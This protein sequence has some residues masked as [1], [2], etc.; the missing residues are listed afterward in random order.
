MLT[1]IH[2]ADFHLDSPL[3]GLARYEGAPA[4]EIRKASRRALN[5]LVDYILDN[6]IPLLLI[7]GDL[8]DADCPDFQTLLYFSLQMDRL[9]DGGT[10]VA[11]I[12]GNH[13][14]G[15]TMTRS[16]KLPDNVKTFRS[17]HPHTW[18][19]PDLGV[20]IHGQSYGSYQVVDNLALAYPDPVPDFFN[21]GILHT[22]IS[23][24]PGYSGY[25][26]CELNHLLAKGY[27]YWALGHM[28]RPEIIHE[29]PYVIFPGCI[30]GRHIREPGPKGCMRVDVDNSN[31]VSVEKIDLDIFR[32]ETME[33]DI[34]GL[35]TFHQV[36]DQTG[37]QTEDLLSTK[38]DGRPM[39]TRIIYKGSTRAHNE[40]MQNTEELR[41]SIR[42][43]V[44][45]ISR[46]RIWVE[47]IIQN[48]S[49][50]IDL[51]KLKKSATPQG[52]LAR[53]IDELEENPQR[54]EE[55]GFDLNDL[56]ARLSGSGV[57]VPDLKDPAKRGE[58]LDKA[59]SLIIFMLSENSNTHKAQSG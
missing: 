50:V 14:A 4:D 29:N 44:T 53:Y 39:A 8:Y 13:D 40:L 57:S 6:G 16:L 47:K 33:V 59:R 15:N 46:G 10:R 35:S 36:V 30:Q 3:R 41:A 38:S 18:R 25:A 20:A 17:A 56:A 42:R 54:F 49:P 43:V 23:G 9:K 7:A 24:R 52:D 12:R 5:G 51:E 19:I 48:T 21:I 34:S 26:P 31:A 22:S 32:W 2:A 28:H 11:L 37:I 45:D 1:F 55:L 27:D 58:M